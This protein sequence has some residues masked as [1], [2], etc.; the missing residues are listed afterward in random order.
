MFKHLCGTVGLGESSLI[1]DNAVGI[2][3]CCWHVFEAFAWA[4]VVDFASSDICCEFSTIPVDCTRRL[5]FALNCVRIMHT[6]YLRIYL[7]LTSINKS[8]PALVRMAHS[9]LYARDSADFRLSIRYQS[10][11][12]HQTVISI[13]R[14]ESILRLLWSLAAERRRYRHLFAQIA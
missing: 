7:T 1:L 2:R 6:S 3:D 11:Q 12:S 9:F 14:P 4:A 8:L 13:A 5:S 10:L